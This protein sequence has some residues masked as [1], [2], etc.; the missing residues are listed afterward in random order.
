MKQILKD[1]HQYDDIIHLP[2]P[3]SAVHP[4]MSVE[5]RAAQFAPFAAL[6]GYEE[7]VEETGRR[8]QRRKILEED[9]REELDRILQRILENRDNMKISITYFVPDERKQ[10][11]SYET[12]EGCIHRIDQ[13]ERILVLDNGTGIPLDD[14]MNLEILS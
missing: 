2:H 3:V 5:N 13:Y 6:T 4:P 12:I 14:I 11:G 8:T 9:E 7:A 1:S 10:G